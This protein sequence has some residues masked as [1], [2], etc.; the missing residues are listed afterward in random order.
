M[1]T[2]RKVQRAGLW[3]RVAQQRRENRRREILARYH[4]LVLARDG[5]FCPDRRG[6]EQQAMRMVAREYGL[7]VATIKRIVRL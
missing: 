7:T 5:H 1:K 6:A 2:K 4:D 3:S